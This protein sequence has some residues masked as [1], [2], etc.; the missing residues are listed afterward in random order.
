MPRLKS[1]SEELFLVE[2]SSVQ[3]ANPGILFALKKDT[4]VD[5][6]RLSSRCFPIPG[7]AM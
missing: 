6:V 3:S 2:I 4:D 7:F 1:F 5:N